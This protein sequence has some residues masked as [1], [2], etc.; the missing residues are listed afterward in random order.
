[1]NVLKHV[2]DKAN[3][4]FTVEQR[5]RT[6]VAW[7]DRTALEKEFLEAMG[8]GDIE[9]LDRGEFDI[10]SVEWNA[11]DIFLP[12]LN[13]QLGANGFTE[14]CVAKL[15]SGSITPWFFLAGIDNTT[16]VLGN[17]YPF[18]SIGSTYRD[19]SPRTTSANGKML[20][21]LQ[22]YMFGEVEPSRR[23]IEQR[24]DNTLWHKPS[25]ENGWVT[26]S[27]DFFRRG[28]HAKRKF[29]FP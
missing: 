15:V 8:Y 2:H 7:A 16:K 17:Y 29:S 9:H 19:N 1:M 5:V 24:K 28:F 27:T 4:T 12:S 22:T 23:K 20:I 3:L 26:Y 14:W 21:A 10:I 6:G 13:I 25:L 11:T 18:S